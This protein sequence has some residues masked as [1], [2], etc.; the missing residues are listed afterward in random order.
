[1]WKFF[2]AIF[3]CELFFILQIFYCK[4]E[5]FVLNNI[6]CEDLT[7][8]LW[9][10][11]LFLCLFW[12]TCIW[13][14]FYYCLVIFISILSWKFLI[15]SETVACFLLHYFL[16][17]SLYQ[18]SRLLNFWLKICLSLPPAFPTFQILA[19]SS[20]GLVTRSWF[21]H[22]SVMRSATEFSSGLHDNLVT[23]CVIMFKSAMRFS[24]R[25]QRWIKWSSDRIA[26]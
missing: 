24:D 12:D 23:D 10:F 19:E 22:T 14:I 16:E 18:K 8:G 21:S 7:F 11:Y 20:D 3:F 9:R 26:R 6:F 2:S 17:Q 1:L 5:S 4:S 13:R 25:D 15:Q